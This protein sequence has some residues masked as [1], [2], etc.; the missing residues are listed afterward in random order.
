MEVGVVLVEVVG[1]VGVGDASISPRNAPLPLLPSLFF[2]RSSSS[3]SSSLSGVEGE[4]GVAPTEV[5]VSI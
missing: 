5:G 3:S 4:V 2:S 1:E